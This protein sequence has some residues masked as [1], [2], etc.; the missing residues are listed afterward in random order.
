MRRLKTFLSFSSALLLSLGLGFVTASSASAA[1]CVGTNVSSFAQIQTGLSAGSSMCLTQDLTQTDFGS[2]GQLLVPSGISPTLDLN[3]YGITFTASTAKAA[4]QIPIGATLTVTDSVGRGTINVT[5]GGF[6]SSTG[7]AAGI[8]GDG[9]AGT[10]PG[11]S[12]G[13]L[14]VNGGSITARGGA[15]TGALTAGAG[16]GGGGGG[17]NGTSG[18]NGGAGGTVI[19][20]GGQIYAYG[21]F[22]D[23][24]T[25]AGIGGGSAQTGGNAGAG[26]TLTFNASG[27]PSSPGNGYA[28]G[29]P[30]G[31]LAAT[32]SIGTPQNSVSFQ[33]VSQDS[34]NYSGGG[35]TQITFSYAIIFDSS[36]GSP[37]S[38]GSVVFGNLATEPTNPTR[39]GFVFNGWRTGSASG[40]NYVF[41]DLV[42]APVTLFANW[43]ANSTPSP[44]PTTDPAALPATGFDG[45]SSALFTGIAALIVGALVLSVKRRRGA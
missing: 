3:G 16:I 40:Q 9:G 12:A 43:T 8:G 45:V 10:N 26:G 31:G 17:Y 15:S 18:G 22:S 32:A 33:Q 13:T 19:L 1:T 35:A 7:S 6:A 2:T 25:G 42:I 39:S 38:Q 29:A 27:T 28:I 34:A 36:G 37:V 23:S 30:R 21:G 41:T 11:M 24:S 4:I 20:N 14:I 5:G 44:Q